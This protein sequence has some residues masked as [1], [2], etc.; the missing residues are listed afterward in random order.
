MK[1]KDGIFKPK[2]LIV[3]EPFLPEAQNFSQAI[4]VPKWND[5]MISKYNDFIHNH[6]WVLVPKETHMM[7]IGCQC[8]YKTKT[9]PR[10]LLQKYKVGLW[11]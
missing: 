1:A 6:T 5:V 7:V 11:L 3:N 2:A 9:K 10:G 4:V 8:I